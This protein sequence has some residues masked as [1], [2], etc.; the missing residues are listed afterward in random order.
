M[1]IMPEEERLETLKIL[2]A[3]RVE[4]EEEIQKLPFVIETPSGLK[5]KN[6]LER[7]LKEIDEARR[8]FSRSKV[9]VK[10]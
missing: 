2:D 1:R 3:N 4:I 9:L 8:I 10:A 6:Q 7:R 5:H